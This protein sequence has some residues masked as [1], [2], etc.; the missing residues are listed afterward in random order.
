MGVTL[1]TFFLGRLK[2]PSNLR[3]NLV[4]KW[5]QSSKKTIKM[6]LIVMK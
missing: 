5:Q 4:N 2:L 6:L 1:Q 3:N